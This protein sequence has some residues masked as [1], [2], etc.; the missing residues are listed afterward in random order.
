M[1]KYWFPI[2]LQFVSYYAFYHVLLCQGLDNGH[3]GL[4]VVDGWTVTYTYHSV[5]I[6]NMDLFEKKYFNGRL[7]LEILKLRLADA[8]VFYFGILHIQ[9]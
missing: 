9:H 3:I 8:E 2:Y 4:L 5:S 1:L 6:V 7:A